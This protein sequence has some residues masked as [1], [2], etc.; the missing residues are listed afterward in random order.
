MVSRRW[1]Q[2]KTALKWATEVNDKQFIDFAL[3]MQPDKMLES[4]AENY[5]ACG[6]VQPRRQ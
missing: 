3:K 4:A 6:A 1:V 5:N 2:A